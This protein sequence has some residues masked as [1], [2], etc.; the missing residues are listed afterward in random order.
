MKTIDIRTFSTQLQEGMRSKLEAIAQE[1]K[2]IATRTGKSLVIVKSSMDELKVFVH[3][4]KF[5]SKGDEINFFKEI[6]PVFASQYY[7]FE[8]LLALEIDK[9]AGDTACHKAYYYQEMERLHQ[10]IL[11]NKAFYTYYL[12]A[13]TDL[14]EV[15]FTIR[16]DSCLPPDTDSHFSTGYDKALAVILANQ[17][18]KAYLENLIK[19]LC[20]DPN[21]NSPLTWTTKKAY[22]VE[23]IYALHAVDAF[24][25]GRAEI[26]QIANLFENLFNV[27]LGN[28]YRH[29]SEIGIRKSGQTNFID[30]LKAR[31]EQK[32]DEMS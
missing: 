8:K 2:E 20:G 22:L 24:N 23:L 5:E 28:F 21:A 7:Y 6:K 4:Y 18:L 25:G 31:L 12:S 3:R 26:K 16:K 11:A 14:D 30:Q 15:Y 32:F 10:Y 29:F 1:N 19:N 17:M 9:P 27:S 13:S